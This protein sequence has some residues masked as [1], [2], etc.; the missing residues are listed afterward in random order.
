MLFL[1]CGLISL[2]GTCVC[3]AAEIPEDRSDAA[4]LAVQKTERS[5]T[6][7]PP[8]GLSDYTLHLVGHAHIDPVY[9]WR[10][11]ETVH[12]V[13]RDTFRG[14]LDMM[15]KEP[16]LIFVQSRKGTTC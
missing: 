11:N 1:R 3:L 2:M 4:S 8:P 5:E 15:D 9:R 7:P 6:S 10:W 13:A 16:G 12:R 14:V